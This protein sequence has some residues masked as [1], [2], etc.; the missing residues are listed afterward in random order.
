MDQWSIALHGGAGAIPAEIDQSTQ[1]VIV[2]RLTDIVANSAAMLSAGHC[3]V[4][5]VQQTV[6]ALEDDPHFNAGRG[7]V[8]CRDGRHELEASMM[9][10]ATG[11]AGAATLLRS[12]RHPIA[13]AR[14]IMDKGEY[15]LLSGEAAERIGIDAR[16][17]QVDNDWFQTPHRL[18]ALERMLNSQ[19][20]G[21]PHHATVGAVAFDMKGQL[22]AAT[23]TGG[24]TGKLPGRI[25]D[26]PII[27]AGT[28]ADRQVAVSC[29]GR[30]ED[31]IRHAT[32]RQ[33]AD[34]MAFGGATLVEAAQAT[35]NEMP[36][37]AGGLVAVGADG[38]VTMPFTSA[39]MYRASMATS[40][41]QFVGIGA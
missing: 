28:W 39:G 9:N 1:R 5:V 27:G 7:A 23:S 19:D 29:T 10:G 32:A 11:Q 31:F 22:A 15:V 34:R 8:L 4:D 36:P 18:A 6:E 20:D 33:V 38:T 3:A 14:L 16:L 13:L 24:M 2:Q 30:G 37:A 35:L 40:G 21:E 17:E 25:G 41:H 12:T 26:T